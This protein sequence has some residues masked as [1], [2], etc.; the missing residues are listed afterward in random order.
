MTLHTKTGNK[1]PQ[2]SCRSGKLDEGRE[3][4]ISYLIAEG[5]C[6]EAAR[7]AVSDVQHDRREKDYQILPCGS[8]RV[9]ALCGKQPPTLIGQYRRALN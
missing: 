9:M 2:G 3:A 6:E 8:V 5:A 4:F 1:G 7:T